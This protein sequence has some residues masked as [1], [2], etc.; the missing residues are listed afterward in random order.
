MSDISRRTN[1]GERLFQ[2]SGTAIWHAWSKLH[3]SDDEVTQLREEQ[4]YGGRGTG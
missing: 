4:C 2:R 1:A 3:I